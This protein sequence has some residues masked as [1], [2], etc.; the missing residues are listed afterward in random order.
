MATIR[1]VAKLAGVSSITV[2][3]VINNSGYVSKATRERV[4]EAITQLNYIPNYLATSLRSKRTDTIALVVT[5]VTNPFWTTVARG[6]EDVAVDRG[7]SVILCNTDEDPEKETRYIQILLRRQ[8][9][10]ILVAPATDDGER[11]L[12][13]RHQKIPCVILD[14]EVRHFKADVVRCDSVAGSRELTRHLLDIGYR[15]IA[16]ISGPTTVSTA[17]DRVQGYRQA[18]QERGLTVDGNLVKRGEYKQSSGRRL[19]QEIIADGL[20]P[21]AVFAANNFIAVGAMEAI[22]EAGLRVPEDIALVCF[23]D[24]PQASLIYPFLTIVAQPAYEIGTTSAEL[25]LEQLTGKTQRKEREIV[26]ETELIIRESC[27]QYL[28]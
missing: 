2:S 11:L 12:S 18:L 14:R 6:V 10:G 21:S 26:L 23:D 19:M 5:D 25:L 9:D 4:E 17:E 22:R 3:R 16:V 8:V 20:H 13:I 28:R 7:F 27:G 24:L 15:C 1:D